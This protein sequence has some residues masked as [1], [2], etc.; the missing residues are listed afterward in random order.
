MVLQPITRNFYTMSK[1]KHFSIRIKATTGKTGHKTTLAEHN[2]EP[3]LNKS[4]NHCSKQLQKIF[5]NANKPISGH[6]FIIQLLVDVVALN[7]LLLKAHIH[8]LH[9]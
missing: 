6:F 9:T 4:P 7:V 5:K 3:E 8:T 2:F 1:Q